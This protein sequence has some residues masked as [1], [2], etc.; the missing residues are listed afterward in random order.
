MGSRERGRGWWQLKALGSSF[1][2]RCKT[3]F[4]YPDVEQVVK[5]ADG[6]LCR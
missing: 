1:R 5:Q 2:T 6:E 3:V 4:W